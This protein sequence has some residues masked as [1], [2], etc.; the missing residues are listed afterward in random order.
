[1]GYATYLAAAK[2]IELKAQEQLQTVNAVTAKTVTRYF[3]TMEEQLRITA[4]NRMTLEALESFTKGFKSILKEN[5]V[6]QTE[7]DEARTR[8]ATYYNGEF[9][10]EFERQTNSEAPTASFLETDRSRDE[11]SIVIFELNQRRVN[12]IDKYKIIKIY[13]APRSSA[14]LH[15]PNPRKC[16]RAATFDQNHGLWRCG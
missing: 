2:A 7:L 13:G 1:M 8:L 15:H 3:N 5:A 12:N 14:S 9:A 4:D 11:N 16:R 6:T 10:S